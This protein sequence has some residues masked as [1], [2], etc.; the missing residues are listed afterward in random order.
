MKCEITHTLSHSHIGNIMKTGK[1]KF[2]L[3]YTRDQHYAN[4][5]EQL[6]EL[7]KSGY[8]SVKKCIEEHA[9]E[10]EIS[11]GWE[12]ELNKHYSVDEV[13]KNLYSMGGQNGLVPVTCSAEGNCLFNSMS[14]LLLGNESLNTELHMKTVREFIT[15]R[16]LYDKL[17]YLKY[18]TIKNESFEEEVLDTIKDGSYAGIMHI[19]VFAAVTNRHIN[20]IYPIAENSLVDRS[21]FHRY[22]APSTNEESSS[23]EKEGV[24][25]I[26]WTHTRNKTLKGWHPNHFVHC[27][28][29]K[30]LSKFLGRISNKTKCKR[31]KEVKE[32][33]KKRPKMETTKKHIKSTSRSSNIKGFITNYFAKARKKS[34]DEPNIENKGDVDVPFI[35]NES[36]NKI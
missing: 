15:N 30:D 11:P 5:Q 18:T 20:S 7:S 23:T 16:H 36:T 19:K 9:D 6:W 24:F 12:A 13:A 29:I 32:D 1:N 34:V 10:Y 31:E 14:I 26:M 4:L 2:F 25:N 33:F 21:F 8:L 22:I 28:S 17:E 3:K 35:S 27:F